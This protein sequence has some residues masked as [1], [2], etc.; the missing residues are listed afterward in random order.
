MKAFKVTK[1]FLWLKISG[2]NLEGGIKETNN[3]RN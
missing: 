3:I 1:Y 2:V